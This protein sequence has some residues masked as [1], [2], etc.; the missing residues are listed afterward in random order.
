VSVTVESVRAALAAEDYGDRLIAVNQL[1]QLEP[2]VA[3][4]LLQTVVQDSNPRV[5]YAA[6][7]QMSSLG[8]QNR[9]LSLNILRNCLGDS[10]T[11]VRAAAADALGA[12]KLREAYTELEQLYHGST[13]WML[14]FSIVAALGELGAPESY[15]L[16]LEA[17]ST[18]EDLLKL[19]A[20]GSLGELGDSRAVPVLA[21]FI[22]HPDWQVRHRV[23]QALMR[24]GGEAVQPMLAR[25]AEDDIPQ[26]AEAA[27]TPIH[28]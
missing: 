18:G 15:P 3:F 27:T 13:D 14:Q 2:A 17:L 24:L 5:R 1:R 25:L 23:A 4:E 28:P 26:V 9:E 8:S 16:L 20:I 12:L 11:D 19:A 7:S 10:E 21:S 22:S 6:V